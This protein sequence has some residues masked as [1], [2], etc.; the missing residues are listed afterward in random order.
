MR[1]IR[2][3]ACSTTGRCARDGVKQSRQTTRRDMSKGAAD[4]DWILPASWLHHRSASNL[5]HAVNSVPS[6]QGPGHWD[7]PRPLGRD[8]KIL[9]V[10]QARLVGGFRVCS[11]LKFSHLA[12]SPGSCRALKTFLLMSKAARLRATR[13]GRPLTVPRQDLALGDRQKARHFTGSLF[14][15]A[16]GASGFSRPC[17][18]C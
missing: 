3:T 17:S 4:C 15:D 9:G 5:N 14:V 1:A 18:S 2:P 11:A 16:G 8:P 7:T 13:L 6:L 10:S 12:G